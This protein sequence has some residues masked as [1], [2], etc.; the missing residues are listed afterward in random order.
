MQGLYYFFKEHY[1]S[2]SLKLYRIRNVLVFMRPAEF[3]CADRF[4]V[5]LETVNEQRSTGTDRVGTKPKFE[6]KFSDTWKVYLRLHSARVAL[7][8]ANSLIAR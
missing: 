6:Y 4:S 2:I 7:R 3:N 8:S 5:R 1:D